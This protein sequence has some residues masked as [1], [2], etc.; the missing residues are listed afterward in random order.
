[1]KPKDMLNTR[2]Q[3]VTRLRTRPALPAGVA[4]SSS[5]SS[6]G[7]TLTASKEDPFNLVNA[8]LRSW[9]FTGVPAG[10]AGRNPK[11]SSW[12]IQLTIF[13]K[14]R[15]TLVPEVFRPVAA[16]VELRAADRTG[17]APDGGLQFL[18]D[19]AAGVEDPGR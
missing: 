13:A 4:L 7:G 11:Q 10:I 18:V 5:H 15:Q 14:P 16:P 8:P 17:P 2:G 9:A 12:Q 3:P 6:V 19:M 1:M